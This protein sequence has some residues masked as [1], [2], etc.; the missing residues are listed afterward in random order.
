MST[1]S[2]HGIKKVLIAGEIRLYIKDKMVNRIRFM[3]KNMRDDIISEWNKTHK[4]KSKSNYSFV[5]SLD[6]SCFKK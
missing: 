1:V 5:I 3:Y 2:E 4:L 6:D